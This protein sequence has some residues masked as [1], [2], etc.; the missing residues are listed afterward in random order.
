MKCDVCRPPVAATSGQ[1]YARS[2]YIPQYDYKTA[3]TSVNIENNRIHNKNNISIRSFV[4][5]SEE[6]LIVIVNMY[7]Q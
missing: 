5:N 6:N 3:K 1:I 4:I 2:N 7:I